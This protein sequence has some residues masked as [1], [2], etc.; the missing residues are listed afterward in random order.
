MY[1][2]V[3]HTTRFQYSAPIAEN[4]MEVWLQPR[5]DDCQYCQSFHLDMRPRARVHSFTDYLSNHVHH[6]DIAG[7]HNELVITT[8]SVVNVYS[9]PS[10]PPA[11]AMTAWAQNDEL[12]AKA[13]FW[14]MTAASEF[15]GVTARLTALGAELN[16]SRN[17]DPLTVLINLNR[18]INDAFDY[19]QTITRVDSPID[20]AIRY[21]R[22]VC[23][24]FSHVMLALVRNMLR[25]PARY[26]SGYLFH[27]ADDTSVEDASHAW[28]EVY[29]PE[30]GW[31]GFDPTNNIVVG[32][33]HIR[34]AIGRD[35]RD[36]PPTRGVFKGN[37]E[38]ELSVGVQVRAIERPVETPALEPAA[39]L[40]S[41]PPPP[42][43]P[44]EEQDQSQQQSQQ[45]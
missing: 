11:L 16:V 1:Y 13:E 12:S 40:I 30:L 5:T 42:Y 39:E 43:L 22:G 27:R 3:L 45:Q 21:R 31:V 7:A 35:Y 4:V 17:A 25:M 44:I 32:E 19:D 15:T 29:L 34:V 26:V 28:I 8:Q 41:P 36:V 20:E 14:E 23:Q 38:T 18:A 6:F 24:D 10:L 33:R 2:S 37:A 9:P